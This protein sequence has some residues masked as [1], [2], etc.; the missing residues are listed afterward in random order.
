MSKAGGKR[1]GAGR[2]PLPKGEGK[3][4]KMLNFSPEAAKH[5]DQ[6]HNMSAYVDG[7]IKEDMMQESKSARLAKQLRELT[8]ADVTP[9]GYRVCSVPRAYAEY[10][11]GVLFD[12]AAW[13]RGDI[14]AIPIDM[15]E[16]EGIASDDPRRPSRP[17]PLSE[18][19]FRKVNTLHQADWVEEF[20]AEQLDLMG[21]EPRG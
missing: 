11:G 12:K 10:L 4:R 2:R 17:S 18:A 3:V 19:A 7:L 9:E 1:K 13:V 21:V 20:I 8:L 6:K 15:A 14:A 16:S 5:L